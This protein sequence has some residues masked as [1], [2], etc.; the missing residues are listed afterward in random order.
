M[1]KSIVAVVAAVTLVAVA[2]EQKPF[3]PQQRRGNPQ[4]MRGEGLMSGPILRMALNE[5]VMEM[6]G[7]D[8]AQKAKLEELAKADKQGDARMK[9]RNEVMRDAMERQAKLLEAEKIDETAVMSSIDEVFELR[10][11]MAKEQTRRLIALRAVLSAEQIGKIREKMKQ[12]AGGEPR[13]NR[14][15]RRRGA[16]QPSEVKTA[17]QG[18]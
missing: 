6:I 15:E 11:E 2:E 10:K 1:K 4:F 8:E 14:E 12:R 3:M 13:R 9:L 5:Q 16:P 17:E 18:D 7:V